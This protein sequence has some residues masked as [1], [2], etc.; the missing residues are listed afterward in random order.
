MAAITPEAIAAAFAPTLKAALDEQAAALK[1]EF[2]SA[3]TTTT[4][5]LKADFDSRLAAI[6]TATTE[7]AAAKD[8]EIDTLKASVNAIVGAARAT[9]TARGGF[10]AIEPD[11][12][13]RKSAA[14]AD[15]TNQLPVISPTDP[16]TGPQGAIRRLLAAQTG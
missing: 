5:A 14:L 10:A 11:G 6:E 4:D 3:L 2:A 8:D 9:R 1:G 16:A 7:K 12:T 15:G 13:T